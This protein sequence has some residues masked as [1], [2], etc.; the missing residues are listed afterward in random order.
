MKDLDINKTYTTTGAKQEHIE[1]LFKWLVENDIRWGKGCK[2]PLIK[3]IKIRYYELEWGYD[4][5]DL[6]A[7]P[8]SELFEEQWTPKQGDFILINDIVFN[9]ALGKF[10]CKDEEKFIVEIYGKLEKVD[11]IYPTKEIPTDLKEGDWVRDVFGSI[12]KYHKNASGTCIK[13]ENENLIKL[14]EK[15]IK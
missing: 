3:G 13:I 8:I 7:T 10:I 14:L 12:F 4:F 15:E 5:S 9:K 11:N 2:F 1:E 6:E